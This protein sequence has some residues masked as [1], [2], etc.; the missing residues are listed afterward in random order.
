MSPYPLRH[1]LSLLLLPLL[2][3]ACEV[4]DDD[5]AVD[6]D[7]DIFSQDDDDDIF[8]Q[9]DD[10]DST[11]PQ[12]DDDDSSNNGNGQGGDT[13][14]LGDWVDAEG[15]TYSMTDSLWTIVSSAGTSTFSLTEF[16]TQNQFAVGQNGADN[17]EHPSLFSRFE[18][19]PA[20]GSG[21]YL[22]HRVQDAVDSLRA[23]GVEAGDPSNPTVTGCNEGPWTALSPN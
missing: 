16:S 8:S 13:N 6:D 17:P 5:D 19:I 2:F 20:E 10:D 1:L 7:D 9:D 3:A 23:G 21:V 11:P 14:I 18:W 12:G 4:S 15:S 22:C